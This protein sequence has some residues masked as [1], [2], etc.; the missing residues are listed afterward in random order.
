ME[1]IWHSVVFQWHCNLR[2]TI[3]DSRAVVSMV[4]Y[5]LSLNSG[6]LAGDFYLNF[7]LSGLVEFPAYTLCLLLLDR[8]GR[9]KLHASCMIGGGIACIL[10][11]FPAFYLSKCE[12]IYSK[13]LLL[14]CLHYFKTD[15]INNMDHMRISGNEPSSVILSQTKLFQTLKWFNDIE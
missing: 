4:Y 12:W 14:R 9:K 2:V 5:G 10:T 11:T 7:L 8:I 15:L 6:N 13:R 1:I 3:V